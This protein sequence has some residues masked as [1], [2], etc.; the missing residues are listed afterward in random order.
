MALEPPPPHPQLYYTNSSFAERVVLD[1]LLN[2]SEG[3][4]IT[5]SQTDAA[6]IALT[7][8][9]GGGGGRGGGGA[10]GGTSGH[11]SVGDG[12]GCLNATVFEQYIKGL[13]KNA[14]ML[15][16][17]QKREIEGDPLVYIIAV[18]LFYSCGIAVLMINY[19]KKVRAVWVDS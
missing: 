4:D 14:T 18:L 12:S 10:G 9:P 15:T 5:S 2:A 17:A 1:A 19:M 13:V 11:G 3:D 7:G 6:R 16:K 8:G